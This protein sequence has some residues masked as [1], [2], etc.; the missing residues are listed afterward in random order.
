MQTPQDENPDTLQLV[1]DNVRNLLTKSASFR[2]LPP[3]KQR[4]VAHDTV[5]VARFIS[6]AGGDTAGVPMMAMINNPSASLGT[7]PVRSRLARPF[8]GITQ[9]TAPGQNQ[10]NFD[11]ASASFDPAATSGF[12]GQAADLVDAID[13]PGFV[14]GLIQGVFTAIVKTSIQQME[15]YATLVAN[16]AKSV[17]QY[18]ADNVSPEQAKD[19]LVTSQPDLFEPDMGGET[20]T[21]KQRADANPDQMGGF[22]K[23]LGL[24]FDLDTSDPEVVQQEVVP[25]VRTQMAMDRQKL[26]ATMVMMGINRIVVTDGRIQAAVVFDLSAKDIQQRNYNRATSFQEDYTRR[27]KKKKQNGW[28]IFSNESE[29]DNS[30]LNVKTS[31]TTDQTDTSTSSVEL[32]TKLTGNVDLRFKSDY[33]PMEKMLDMLGTNQTAITQVAQRPTPAQTANAAAPPL[34][35]LPPIPPAPAGVAR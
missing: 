9:P 19:Q 34:P 18:M 2:S 23:G 13:F 8:T 24:P 15:A 16:V 30:L 14:A 17:D 11:P 1:R 5:K 10:R 29:T 3:E 28:W 26:L 33:F 20:P 35:A 22:L 7:A 25:A 27:T 31:T 4:Q 32:K 6:D 21:V 12:A